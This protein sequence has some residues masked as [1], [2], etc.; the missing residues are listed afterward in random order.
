MPS[1][2]SVSIV[3]VPCRR[4]TQAARWNGQAPQTTTGAASVSESHCQL[5]NCQA[6]TIARAITGTVSSAETI[7][8]CRSDRV[9]SSASSSPGSVS[10][11]AGRGRAAPYPACSTVRTSSAGS[12]PSG[13]ATLAFSVA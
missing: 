6:G 12:R 13:K 9:G 11:V 2:T 1:E 7:R 5:V 4:L 10:D 3:D 8:R